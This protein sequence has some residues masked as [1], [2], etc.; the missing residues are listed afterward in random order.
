MTSTQAL[1]ATA[2]R[3]RREFTVRGVVQGVGFRPFV[4]AEATALTLSGSVLNNSEGVIIEVEGRPADVEA[5][6]SRLRGNAPP[7]AIVTSIDCRDRDVCGG[8]DFVITDSVQVDGVRT[9]AP[10]DIATCPDCLREMADPTNR[11]Y[12][13]PFITCTN[14]GPRFTIIESLPY[15]RPATTMSDFAMCDSC[16]AEYADPT[17][18]RFHAQPIACRECGPRLEFLLASGQAAPPQSY[19]PYWA[20]AGDQAALALAQREL[21]RGAILA[22]KGMGGYHLA[23]D[24]FNEAAVATLRRRK[25]RNDKPFAIMVRDVTVAAELTVA[26]ASELALMSSGRRPIVLIGRRPGTDVAEAVAPGNADLGVMLPYTPVHTLLFTGGNL[27]ALVMTSANLAGEPIVFEDADALVR[28]ADIADGWLRHD[29]RILVPVDD[30]V[31]RIVDGAELPLRRSRGYAPLPVALP[32]DVGPILAVGADLKNAC[33]VG[34]G[35]NAWLSQHVG[36]M[37][38]LRT[39]QAFARTSAHLSELTGVSP[40]ELAA[41]AHP[42]YRSGQWARRAGLPVH[43]VQHHHAHVASLMAEHGL[44]GDEPIIGFAFDGTGF[45]T[46][47]AIWGGELLIADYR[48]FHRFAHLQY[49]PL[50]GGDASVERPYRMAL[51]HLHSAGV[52]WSADLPCV[53]ACPATERQLLAQQLG[54][55]FGCVPTSSM[56]RLFDAVSALAGIRQVAGYEA[57]AAIELEAASRGVPAGRPY[58]YEIGANGVIGTASI[59]RAAAMDVLA[60]VSPDVIGARFHAATVGLVSD[61]AVRA[62]DQLGLNTVGLTGGVFQNATLLAGASAALRRRGF[63][64]L[65]HRLV[66]PNDGGIALGQ[67]VIAANAQNVGH[68][69]QTA[70]AR[71]TA[72]AEETAESSAR[73]GR[74]CA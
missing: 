42:G 48:Q 55:G 51:A 8:S 58:H 37:D 47:D 54:S 52:P 72:N 29:R 27:R 22:V 38:D 40:V 2:E 1:S 30:S 28:L 16:A 18:R 5:F 59:I 44:D 39:L 20:Q 56:G 33:C 25:G 49:V 60:G 19:R 73:G 9:L 71:Q 62:R 12:R 36:D 64:V 10:P 67:L 66:P 70:N 61:L 3:V 46:D 23:C 24:A 4:Y 14:C 34:D 65:R 41:D 50:A 69:Q 15:D 7:L 45:G 57:Q 13:H 32:F 21:G 35:R 53:S 63:T 43:S 17:D 11:R 74:P 6:G 68:A 31:T 26:D